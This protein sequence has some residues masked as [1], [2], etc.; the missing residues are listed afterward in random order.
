MREEI[1]RSNCVNEAYDSSGYEYEEPH[2][3]AVFDERD[4]VN[5]RCSEGCATNQYS[6]LWC[7]YLGEEQVQ[8]FSECGVPGF[9]EAIC[10]YNDRGYC[11]AEPFRAS[12]LPTIYEECFEKNNMN[13]SICSDECKEALEYMKE[14]QGCCTNTYFLIPLG[15]FHNDVGIVT[16]S[17]E[18]FSAC[19]IEIPGACKRFP[20]PEE[21]L[22]C[23]HDSNVDDDKDGDLDDDN[24]GDVDDDKDGDV[25]NDKGV[26]VHVTP[27]IF[28]IVVLIMVSF[29]NAM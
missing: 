7:K 19:E 11:G 27:T 10:R 25:D 12:N 13:A 22:E 24:D 2:P 18:L 28:C 9:A 3:C 29:L 6:Y 20:P 5:V 4:D 26:A 14:D 17:E 8:I 1:E 16:L 21:F 23:A 15:V